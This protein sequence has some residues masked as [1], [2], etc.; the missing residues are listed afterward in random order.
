MIPILIFL[1]SWLGRTAVG[2]AGLLALW[3]AF[4]V[5]YEE[6]GA[7]AERSKIEAAGTINE[8]KANKVRDAV[9]KLPDDL[10]RDAYFRN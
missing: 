9:D 3:V 1:R 8:I 4:K 6:T 2:V 7:A 10:L 5:H